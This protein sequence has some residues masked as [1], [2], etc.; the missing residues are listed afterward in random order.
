MGKNSPEETQNP[1]TGPL[2]DF[3]YIDK[4][5]LDSFISQI[6][7]GTLRSVTKIQNTSESSSHSASGDM[8]VLKG[9]LSKAQTSGIGSTEKYDPFYWQIINFLNTLSTNTIGKIDDS[10]LDGPK[11][12]TL[13]GKLTVRNSNSIGSMS[14]TL[15]K[16]PSLFG[17][18]QKNHEIKNGIKMFDE[19][20]RL[21]PDSI[22]IGLELGDRNIVS[23][24]LN[25]SGL[26]IS[27]TDIV[28]QYG[29]TLPGSWFVFGI[30]DYAPS[31][32]PNYE[33][34]FSAS[35]DDILSNLSDQYSNAL[36]TLCGGSPYKIIPVIIY[37]AVSLI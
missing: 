34:E 33:V 14:S 21:L 17:V 36:N 2:V 5:R 37:R 35:K 8:K 9:E 7:T 31:Q 28:Q 19:L 25:S 12:T 11:L 10:L 32:T 23:G 6:T 18:N 16:N 30:F 3:L 4:E 13:K 24:T 15:I 26:Q 1:V 22:T 20:I 27:K 29:A